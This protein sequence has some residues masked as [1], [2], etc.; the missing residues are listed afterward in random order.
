[1][2]WEKVTQASSIMTDNLE[3]NAGKN[4]AL[5]LL[6]TSDVPENFKSRGR[7]VP[8]KLRVDE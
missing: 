4:A 5:T 3:N 1:M 6:N 8:E 2:W 7:S